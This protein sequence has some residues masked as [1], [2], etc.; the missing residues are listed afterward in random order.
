MPNAM[1]AAR[2][3]VE[4]EAAHKLC[5]FDAHDPAFVVAGAPVLLPTKAHASL[6]EIQQAIVGDGDAMSVAR[7]IGQQ[8]L[9]TGESRFCVNYPF[10]CTGRLENGGKCPGPIETHEIAEEP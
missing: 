2:Q 1:E 9:G 6:I 3:H 4:E 8:L 5:N 10:G 7:Q